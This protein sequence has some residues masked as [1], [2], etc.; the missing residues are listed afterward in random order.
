MDFK[1][2]FE[3]QWKLDFK[4]KNE[5]ELWGIDLLEDKILALNVELGELSNELP[6]ESKFWSNKRNDYEKALVEYV[7]CLHFILSI[8]NDINFNAYTAIQ[9]NDANQAGL[10]IKKQL[11]AVY[12][13][14]NQFT[15]SLDFDITPAKNTY[16]QLFN[17]FLF[18][19]RGIGFT[20]EQIA[21]A[22]YSKNETNHERQDNG[23]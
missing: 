23:Y 5:K 15:M 18:L 19:G 20:H 16:N 10:N 13:W 12:D 6:E 7:D 3:T 22:Y 4:I 17:Q 9:S 14:I 8:G 21:D 2:L 1:Q 11:L